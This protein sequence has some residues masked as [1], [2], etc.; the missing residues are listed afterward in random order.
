MNDKKQTQLEKL[1]NIY[2]QVNHNINNQNIKNNDAILRRNEIIDEYIL[3]MDNKTEGVNE[4]SLTSEEDDKDPF[5]SKAIKNLKPIK[6]NNNNKLILPNFAQREKLKSERSKRLP[7]S[8]FNEKFIYDYNNKQEIEC[9]SNTK[10]FSKNNDIKNKNNF[11]DT[12]KC[13]SNPNYEVPN[14]LNNKEKSNNNSNNT[15]S[16]TVNIYPNNNSKWENSA[17]KYYNNY[18]KNFRGNKILKNNFTINNN[19][20]INNNKINNNKINNNNNTEKYCHQARSKSHIGQKTTNESF[21][22][23]NAKR[24]TNSPKVRMGRTFGSMVKIKSIRRNFTAKNFKIKN[25]DENIIKNNNK[26]RVFSTMNTRKILKNKHQIYEKLLNEKNN[27]YG[28][29]WINKLLHKNTG[30]K[31]GVTKDFV[32]GVPIIKLM[33]KGDIS[34]KEL[35]KK[36]S[37]LEKKKNDEFKKLKEVEPICDDKSLDDEYNIPKE[38]LDQFNKNTK[39]FYKFRKD[40]IEQ[41]EDEEDEQTIENH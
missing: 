9:I 4:I 41:P 8:K 22:Y 31:I 6:K 28:I 19:N 7:K 37:E 33:N 34:K 17:S 14:I 24:K 38:I 18:L 25:H 13:A 26:D 10:P 3:N 11:F 16:N 12:K 35:K 15:T 5:S 29:D 40:I 21:N 1:P 23:I 39:N 36:L 30:S 2:P 27:P 20:N 32:N